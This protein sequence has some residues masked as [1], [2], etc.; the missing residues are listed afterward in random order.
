[1]GLS[2]WEFE[3]TVAV[4]ATATAFE[5]T[6]PVPNCESVQFRVR[7]EVNIAGVT[8]AGA[9]GYSSAHS[10]FCGPGL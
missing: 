9:W 5:T 6:V 10:T 8:Q 7:A 4:G 1:M 2:T 3:K